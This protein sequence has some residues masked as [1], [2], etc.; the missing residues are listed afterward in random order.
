MVHGAQRVSIVLGEAVLSKCHSEK[1]LIL[2]PFA[3]CGLCVKSKRSLFS[4]S[5]VQAAC[6]PPVYLVGTY[7]TTHPPISFPARLMTSDLSY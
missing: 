6:P 7:T 5:S 4:A 2:M 1:C 3:H